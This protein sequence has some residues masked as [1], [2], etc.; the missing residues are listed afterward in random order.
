MFADAIEK[1]AQFTRPIHS[2][3]RIYE[4]KKVIPASG[5]LFFV[6]EEGWAVTCKHVVEMLFKTDKINEVYR[7][8][9]AERDKLLKGAKNARNVIKGLETKYHYTEESIIEIRNRFMDC[10]D[11]MSGFTSHMHPQYD[12]ALLHFNDYQELHYSSHAVFKRD[13]ASIRQGDI[14]CRLGYPFPEFTN[15][16]Y[17]ET[18]D[19][20]EWTNEGHSSSP[21]FPIEGMVTRFMG[22]QNKVIGIELST[23]GL[24][25]QS[26]GPLFDAKGIVYGM[27]F[28]T[29]HLHLGFDM[30]EKEILINNKYKKIS[31]YSFMHLG[32]CVHVNIIK[33][34][35]R[36]MNVKFHEDA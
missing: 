31:D 36:E 24:R 16:R 4:G 20:L 3:L 25:G 29:R 23:P 33:D 30:V 10:V 35:M 34:F 32:Q 6:N 14:L 22:E 1:T 17:N 19:I 9:K 28:S 13:G 5:T 12:L 27:Q 7:N 11:K 2:I 18:A 21:R 8:F 15:Y 26:G